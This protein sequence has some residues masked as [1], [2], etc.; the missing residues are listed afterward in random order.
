[1]G[2]KLGKG[3]KTWLGKGWVK[4]SNCGVDLELN[5]IYHSPMYVKFC[6]LLSFVQRIF[7]I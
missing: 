4:V 5:L 2:V 1:M 7:E 3:S 6:N